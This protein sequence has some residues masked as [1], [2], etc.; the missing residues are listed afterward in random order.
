MDTVTITIDKP[1]MYENKYILTI[2]DGLYKIWMGS[3]HQF[4]RKKKNFF[5]S[6]YS[7]NGTM[8]LKKKKQKRHI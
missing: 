1:S 4:K 7:S 2:Q 8:K 3:I 6:I 5:F